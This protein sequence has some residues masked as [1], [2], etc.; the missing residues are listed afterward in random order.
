MASAS[1]MPSPGSSQTEA[2]PSPASG[3]AWASIRR[4]LLSGTEATL[5]HTRQR[6]AAQPT[7]R[8]RLAAQ[9]R[10]SSVP[11]TAEAKAP[12]RTMRVKSY[13]D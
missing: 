5:E 10:M 6:G 2:S 13:I 8:A 3:K 9:A 1:V 12:G 11:L 7:R 4:P